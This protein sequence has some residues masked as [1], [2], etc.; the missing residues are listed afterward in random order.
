[1][2]EAFQQRHY[3]PKEL[4][5]W[6][7]VSPSYVVKLFRRVTGVANFVSREQKTM[8]IPEA[9]VKQVYEQFTKSPALNPQALSVGTVPKARNAALSPARFGVP[10]GWK[11]PVSG[12]RAPRVEQK[13]NL[14]TDEHGHSQ[15]SQS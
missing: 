6:W 15:S 11:R 9:L 14:G 13:K 1:M 3:S 5:E 12:R 8:R 4:A 10:K 2:P 7:G